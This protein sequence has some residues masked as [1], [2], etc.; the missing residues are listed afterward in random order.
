MTDPI[1]LTKAAADELFESPH[2]ARDDPCF[3]CS[4]CG[5]FSE[6]SVDS[7]V[8]HHLNCPAHSDNIAALI[9]LGEEVVQLRKIAYAALSDRCDCPDYAGPDDSP[10]VACLA[11]VWAEQSVVDTP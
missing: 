2:L 10:C 3:L 7:A 9:A 1:K 4:K 6:G 5:R 11:R 8:V